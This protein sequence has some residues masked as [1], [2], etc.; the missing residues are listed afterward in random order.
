MRASTGNAIANFAAEQSRFGAAAPVGQES[1][2]I[3]V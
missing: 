3:A 2:D 1:I